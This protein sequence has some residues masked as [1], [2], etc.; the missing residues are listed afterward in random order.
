MPGPGLIYRHINIYR[1][2]MNALYLG[3]YKKRFIPVIDQIRSLHDNAKV[4]ELC[5]GDTY[6]AAHCKKAG[7]HWIGFDLNARFVRYAQKAG[8]DARQADL[9]SAFELPGADVCIMM[10]SLYH[11]HGHTEHILRKML[12]AA[13]TVILSEPVKNLSSGKGF[14]G[15]LAKRSA[16]AGKGDERFRYNAESF[17]AELEHHRKILKYQIHT[18]IDFGKD[19]IVKLTKNGKAKD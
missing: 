9:A 18:P 8:F 7:V 6:I 4:L 12:N 15:A 17:L 10:G 14:L 11:F 2:V 19:L 3:Q 5:F 13:P 1:A 16:N